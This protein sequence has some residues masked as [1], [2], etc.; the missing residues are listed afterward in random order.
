MMMWLN[1]PEVIETNRLAI[2]RLKYEDAEEIFYSYASKPEVTRFLSWQTHSCIEDTR[3]FLRYAIQNWN[4]GV[5]Y[6]YSIRL[7]ESNELIGGFGLINEMGK[8]QFGYALS[9]ARWNK[10][11]ATEACAKMMEIV[12]K[13]DNIYRV[14]TFVDNDNTSSIRVL[15][16]CGLEKEAVLKKWFRFINQNGEPKDCTL[17]NLPLS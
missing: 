3:N 8:I 10:G 2:Q 11:Y 9:P 5:D 7:K 16:K 4:I 13:L 17:F 1:L 14:S 15:E 6:S 12:K